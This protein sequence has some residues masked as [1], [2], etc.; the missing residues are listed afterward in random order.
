[1]IMSNKKQYFKLFILLAVTVGTAFIFSTNS[2]GQC[3]GSKKKTKNPT[4]ASNDKKVI[5]AKLPLLL[6]LGSKKCIP[7]KKMMPILDKLKKDYKNLLEVSFVDVWI[8]EN[9]PVAKKHKIDMIPTQIFLDAKGK[10]L[11]RHTGFIS[12]ADILKKWKELGY[13]FSALKKV[14]EEKT[15][16]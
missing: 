11:W 12:E 3:C 1:M 13:D 6:E 8:K 4:S 2:L 16:K 9:L 15:E 14:A 10:E 5:K 7:C